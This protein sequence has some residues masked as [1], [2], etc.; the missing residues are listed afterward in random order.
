MIEKAISFRKRD[1]EPPTRFKG[2]RSESLTAQKTAKSNVKVIVRHW[3]QQKSPLIAGQPTLR[4]TR[5]YD[6]SDVILAFINSDEEDDNEKPNATRSG[7]AITR[8]SKIDLVP[9]TDYHCKIKNA[10]FTQELEPV[11]NV[12]VGSEKLM[13]Y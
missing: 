11:F 3:L 9:L 6:S 5:T 13:L 2:R 1:L 8:T 10:S 7:W 12:N 4:N